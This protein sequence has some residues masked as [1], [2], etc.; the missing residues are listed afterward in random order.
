[1]VALKGESGPPGLGMC[2]RQ[3]ATRLV[4]C[5]HARAGRCEKQRSQG[6][7]GADK[8]DGHA[9]SLGSARREGNQ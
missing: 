8:G 3:L 9:A 6:S 1:M 4:V 5:E 7:M 2:W